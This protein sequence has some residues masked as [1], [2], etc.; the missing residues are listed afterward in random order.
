[1]E[2]ITA[3]RV[4]PEVESNDLR[5]GDNHGADDQVRT[6]SDLEMHFVGGGDD[7]PAWKP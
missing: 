2:K 5:T 7:I 4:L 6:L 3:Q 1:M